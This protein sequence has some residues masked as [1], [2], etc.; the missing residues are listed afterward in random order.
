MRD[1]PIAELLHRV[2]ARAGVALWIDRRIDRSERVT[3]ATGPSTTLDVL[4]RIAAEVGGD[5]RPFERLVYVGPAADAARIEAIAAGSREGSSRGLLRRESIE[6]PRLTTPR[7]LATRIADSARRPLANRA[8]IPHDLLPAGSVAKM[9]RADVLT[10]LLIGFELRWRPDRSDATSLRIEPLGDRSQWAAS[11]A[12][13]EDAQ[14]TESDD[15]SRRYTL[16]VLDQPAGAVLR[17][18]AA[19]IGR[20][21]DSSSVGADALARR[22]SFSVEDATLDELLTVVGKSAGLGITA[23]EDRV[24]LRPSQP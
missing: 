23:I 8:A 10:L 14:S 17:Q 9:R 24:V 20:R 5:A 13:V 7:N 2:A 1:T 6:W 15:A 22:I 12:P 11:Q 21:L 3:F 16:R 18:I 19:A 4:G